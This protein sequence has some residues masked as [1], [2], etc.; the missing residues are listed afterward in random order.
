MEV[1]LQLEVG[2][3]RLL[4]LL[5]YKMEVD[6][7]LYYYHKVVEL[8]LEGVTIPI[9]LP[10]PPAP[11]GPPLEPPPA[12]VDP[13]AVDDAVQP[14]SE[15]LTVVIASPLRPASPA[16]ARAYAISLMSG[17]ATNNVATVAKVSHNTNNREFF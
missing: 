5:G 15:H 8:Q 4:G 3:D 1:E 11:P 12:P 6:R 10:V 16:A 2:V 17:A 7:L 14:V 9:L 13:V